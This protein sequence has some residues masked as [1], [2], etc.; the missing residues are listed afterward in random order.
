MKVPHRLF[1]E[2]EEWKGPIKGLQGGLSSMAILWA[3][4]VGIWAHDELNCVYARP[5]YSA[6]GVSG[7]F[8]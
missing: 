7:L 1:K 6:K 8:F 2:G 3:M 4:L 5:R